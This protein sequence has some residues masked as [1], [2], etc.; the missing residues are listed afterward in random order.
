VDSLARAAAFKGIDVLATGDF[1]HPAWFAELRTGLT[2]AADGVYRGSG[3]GHFILGTEI[4]C[5]WRSGERGRRVHVLLLA[6][7]L[8][9]AEKFTATVAKYA[10]LES[11]G[12]PV[13]GLPA[14]QL[15]QIAWGAD[16]RFIVM[17]AHIWTPWYGMYGSKSGFDTVEECFGAAAR[18]IHAVETGL[19]S[20]PAMNWR[21]SD[22]DGRAIL[23]FSDAHS[24]PSLGR[25]LTVLDANVD[26][27][28]IRS[29][30]MDGRVLETVEF[31]PEHGKYHLDGHS[32][33]GVRLLPSESAASDGRCSQCGRLI[34]LGVLNRVEQLAD[35]AE[36]PCRIEKGLVSGPVGRPPFR[37]LVPLEELVS[38]A[39]G[40]GRASQGVRAAC[41]R[42]VSEFGNELAVLTTANAEDIERVLPN[43]PESEIARAVVAVRQR[44]VRIDPGYDGAYGT[45]TPLPP[46]L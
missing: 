22:L 16:D 9:A 4:A 24:A 40:R 34:T 30:L 27:A 37:S 43:R 21:V 14:E 33:C 36:A 15:A 29:A 46:E 19:S 25:E 41:E 26:Y 12:R 28:S 3:G 17:P 10:R 1:T 7:D 38:F 44:R 20:D 23:S 8:D 39:L 5:V 2:E 13:T 45:V 11:D 18:H 31:F 6:P 35:R 32:K 42:L